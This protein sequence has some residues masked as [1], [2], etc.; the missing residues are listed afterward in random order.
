MVDDAVVYRILNSLNDS[1]EHLKSKRGISLEAYKKDRD[2]QAI[3]ERKLE[4]A[5]QACID[6]GN[7]IVSQQNFGSP[8]DYGEIFSLLAQNKVIDNKLAEKLTRMTGFRN[9]LIHEYRDILV[10][11]VYEI[12]Q[13]RLSDF[14]E[15]SQAILDYLKREV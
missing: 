6:I 10:D 1:M 11:K 3:I 15:F 14:Y 13:N 7:H 12:L 9:I 2:I 5:I 8:S 4:T